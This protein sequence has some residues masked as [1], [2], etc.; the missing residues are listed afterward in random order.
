MSL[1]NIIDFFRDITFVQGFIATLLATIVVGIALFLWRR[2]RDWRK[3]FVGMN[4]EPGT[5]Q[6]A[7]SFFNED[8]FN[9]F[10]KA[11]IKHLPYVGQYL[12]DVIYGIDGVKARKKERTDL[13]EK[14]HT[15][16]L[17]PSLKD[18]SGIIKK[19]EGLK[20][21]KIFYGKKEKEC[22]FRWYDDT[23]GE[24]L[25]KKI[26][27][28]H[29]D[30]IDITFAPLWSYIT[31]NGS[32]RWTKDGIY[33]ALCSRC[34]I[35]IMDRL[36]HEFRIIK[37]KTELAAPKTSEESNNDVGRLKNTGKTNTLDL[38]DKKPTEIKQK[39]LAK[40]LSDISR[41]IQ[42]VLF[43]FNNRG[44]G[45][46]GFSTDPVEYMDKRLK[47]LLSDI[48]SAK[49]TA[50][51]LSHILSKKAVTTIVK[52]YHD[53]DK[54]KDAATKVFF[55]GGSFGPGE[56]EAMIFTSKGFELLKKEYC[57]VLD[58]LSVELETE[59]ILNMNSIKKKK[60]A[61][62]KPAETEQKKVWYKKVW[63][64]IVGIVVF[65]TALTTLWL[66]LDKIK[67]KILGDSINALDTQ[68]NKTIPPK[69]AIKGLIEDYEIEL[70][71]YHNSFLRTY[72]KNEDDFVNGK[73][74]TSPLDST[75]FSDARLAIDKLTLD[76][77]RNIQSI[78][79]KEFHTEKFDTVQV[80][81]EEYAKYKLAIDKGNSLKTEIDRIR[82]DPSRITRWFDRI[83]NRK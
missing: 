45:T 5:N 24:K 80:L 9:N 76:L 67:D 19:L 27:Q 42:E 26:V 62:K 38:Q 33:G 4:A 30:D 73:S 8:F 68:D 59:R 66:N 65:L 23:S 25:W 28:P 31:L 35:G 16:F 74:S 12:F 77:E 48:E 37:Q 14:E 49:R 46:I 75:V 61:S 36:I 17:Q 56:T 58:E 7:T 53:V 34:D 71:R 40:Q 21:A 18:I 79:L 39:T 47:I 41:Q 3:H 60:L 54:I 22:D 43:D 72:E 10:I 83:N 63:V 32:G 52:L 6:S 15:A 51:S 1:Q 13:P 70:Q 29:I 69:L 44:K 57:N 50:G 64:F 82:D 20:E 81:S 11:T 78:L 2:L 55:E